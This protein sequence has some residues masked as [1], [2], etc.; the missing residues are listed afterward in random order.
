VEPITDPITIV[1]YNPYPETNTVDAQT[2]SVLT[3]EEKR[4]WVRDNTEIDLDEVAVVEPEPVL[5]AQNKIINLHF[6]SYPE[7]AKA[8][9]KRALDWQEKMS[10]RCV[11][12]AGETLS[13]AIINGT[14]LGPKDI[15]RLSRFLSKNAIHSAKEWSQSCEAVAYYAWGGGDMMAWANEKVKELHG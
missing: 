2:W 7:K 1:D 13:E 3:A 15:R 11:G 6:N 8:N 10:T 9:V 14:P 4:K 12:K 5:P